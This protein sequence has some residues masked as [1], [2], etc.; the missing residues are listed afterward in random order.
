MPRQPGPSAG[1]SRGSRSSARLL[2]A[3][4]PRALWVALVLTTVLV[5]L[6]GRYGPHRD[7]LYFVQAGENLAWAYPDQG[8]LTPLVA[9]AMEG[10]APGSLVALRLPAA[11]AVGAIV[12][13]AGLLACELGGGGRAELIAAACTATGVV[14]LQTGHTLGTTTFDLLV[15]TAVTWLAVRALRTE[16]DRLWLVAGLV[17]GVGLLNKPLPAFLAAGLLAGV[18]IAGP[19][20][21]LRNRWVWAGAGVLWLPWLIWQADNGW[22]QLEVSAA[23]AGGGSASSQPRWALLPFQALL[24]GPVLAPV[25]IA[26]L[27]RLLG[28]PELRA[29]RFLGWTW[30]VLAVLFMATGGKPY[31]LAGLLAL[32]LAAGAVTVDRWL[33]RC[34]AR[35]KRLALAGAV[36]ASA[37][38][39]GAIGLPLL[40]VDRLE[41]V[42][43]ANPDVGETIGWPALAD[44]VAGVRDRLA[45]GERAVLFTRNYGQAGALDRY[46]PDLGLPRAPSAATT[47]TPTAGVPPGSRGPVIVVGFRRRGDLERHFA[48]CTVRARIATGIDNE[49]NGTPVWSCAGPRKP[50]AE[51]WPRLR[52]YG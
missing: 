37:A 35:A 45:G 19:R 26:G 43:A 28:D 20:H 15:W 49:E 9:R 22:P 1:V 46:G 42:I 8:V 30:V 24:V 7:E 50:W 12:V 44:T 3:A 36:A 51:L 11:L 5:A 4:V 16:R 29:Y 25:W 34:R 18:V 2:I 41:P 48:G 32:L 47:A 40:A 39:C 17:L 31:Y 21:L 6:S 23:I 38:I 27:V 14:F 10:L 13:L 33:D 52:R